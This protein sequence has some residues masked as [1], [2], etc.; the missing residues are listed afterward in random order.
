MKYTYKTKGVCSST[1]IFEI[2]DDVI[3]SLEFIGGCNG[4]LK[5]IS[6]LCVGMKVQDV[7]D[8]HPGSFVSIIQFKEKYGEA[9]VYY[10]ASKDISDK[11]H[12]IIMA[13]SRAS[14]QTC[15]KCGA[16]GKIRGDL[17]WI[18]PLCDVHYVDI[19]KSRN[20]N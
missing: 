3:T 7:I 14:E 4:N 15:I 20:R 10:T 12:D 5:G 16:A 18:R 19:L 6:A 13:F 17:P 9:R 2:K 1:I 11:V 8:K